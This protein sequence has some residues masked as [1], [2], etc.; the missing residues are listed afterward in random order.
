MGEEISDTWN[1]DMGSC[2]FRQVKIA[3][4]SVR[5]ILGGF[6]VRLTK[7]LWEV[8]DKIV[9]I[10]SKINPREREAMKNRIRNLHLTG[11]I[12]G[13]EAAGESVL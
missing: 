8:D 7:V 11:A 12:R 4:S 10:E 5:D 1:L 6:D 13:K 2:D 3:G 9:N